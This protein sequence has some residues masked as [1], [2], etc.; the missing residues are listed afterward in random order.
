MAGYDAKTHEPIV[1][2]SPVQRRLSAQD[3]TVILSVSAISLLVLSV[4]FN[5]PLFPTLLIISITA[6]VFLIYGRLEDKRD[7]LR[8]SNAAAEQTEE[9]YLAAQANLADN[10]QDAVVMV[11]QRERV[12]YANPIAKELLKIKKLGR[13]LSTYVREPGIRPVI[14]QALSGEPTDAITYH[15]EDPTE[16][17]IRLMASPFTLDVFDPPRPM[18]LIF[19]YD[20][21][22]YML[23]HS[24]RA[25]FLANASHELKTPVASLLGYIETLRGHA[26]DDPQAQE[27]FLGIM[28][29]QAERM[30]RLISD[31]IKVA[32][33][34]EALVT[35]HQDELIQLILNLLD[36]SVKISS[37]KSQVMISIERI[38]EWQPG[39]AFSETEF[40]QEAS[41]RRI[42]S[43]VTTDQA[44]Y[45]LRLRDQGPGFARDHLPRIGERFY[46]IAGDL[47][48]QEKGTGLGLAIVK[49]I[50]RRHRGGLLIQSGL[51]EGTEFT[52]LIPAA[53]DPTR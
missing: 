15:I 28:Q 47:S 21:T 51:G 50:T 18:A 36:N 39:Q 16:R 42:V 12:I 11:D 31:L 17:H 49:H 27:K 30:Q 8:A 10:I 33:K 14:Q 48:S 20:V 52:V 19:F 24:Q 53:K 40:S 1:K 41:S 34:K 26:K 32:G 46:R 22:E 2:N 23:A 6:I 29:S 45:I 37:A 13:P 7:L 5:A 43:P 3:L 44:H 9:D 38:E 25:D 4:L 35:G